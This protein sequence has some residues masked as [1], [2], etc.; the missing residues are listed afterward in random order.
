KISDAMQGC[1]DSDSGGGSGGFRAWSARTTRGLSTT[2]DFRTVPHEVQVDFT[3]IAASEGF[4]AERADAA[5]AFGRAQVDALASFSA[6]REAEEKNRAASAA[7]RPDWAT[8]QSAAYDFFQT[9]SGERFQ[10][11]ADAGQALLAAM[12]AEGITSLVVSEETA[13]AYLEDL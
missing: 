5:N 11:M 4:S 7:G 10:A 9:R 2:L 1:G 13:A 6:M 8:Q 3:P 12:R